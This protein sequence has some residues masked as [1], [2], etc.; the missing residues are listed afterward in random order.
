MKVCVYCSAKDQIAD[1]YKQLGKELGAWIA[2]DGHTLVFGGATGGLMT[3][4]SRAVFEAK[5]DVIG[6]VPEGIARSGRLSPYCTQLLRV[7][8]MNERKQKMKQEADVFVCLPGSYGTLDEMFDVVAAGTV[9]EHTKP[10]LILNYK[11][12][13]A[14]LRQQIQLMKEQLFIPQEEQYRPVFVDTLEELILHLQQ[15][16]QKKTLDKRL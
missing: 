15:L 1:D 3:E 9:G 14:P 16:S 7:R 13:Y 2:E 10:L 5:A 12:F 8:H 11:G 4:V 6:V